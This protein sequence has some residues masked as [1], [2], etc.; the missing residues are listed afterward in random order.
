MLTN[1]PV[2]YIIC[3]MKLVAHSLAY[4]SKCWLPERRQGFQ[5]MKVW[6]DDVKVLERK[7]KMWINSTIFNWNPGLEINLVDFIKY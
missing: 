2:K 5:A 1:L 4:G 7:W 6:V 3:F